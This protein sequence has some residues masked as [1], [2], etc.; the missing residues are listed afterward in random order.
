MTKLG[1]NQ[2][3]E[4]NPLFEVGDSVRLKSGGPIMTIKKEWHGLLNDEPFTGLYTCTWH[5]Q[6]E[7]NPH[8]RNY[9][10]ETLELVPE[11]EV[12]EFKRKSEWKQIN[13]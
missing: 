11:D 9:L 7:K 2:P 13:M 4:V 10:Q 8:D 6:G 3:Q 12:I 1:E 5:L